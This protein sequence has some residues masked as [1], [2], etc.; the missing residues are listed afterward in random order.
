MRGSVTVPGV[1]FCAALFVACIGAKD[2][3]SR[4]TDCAAGSSCVENGG[5]RVC[6]ANAGGSGGGGSGGTGGDGGSGGSGGG[7][8]DTDGDEVCDEVDRCPSVADPGQED[9]DAD[10]LGDACDACPSDPANDEDGDGACGDV[11][12][13][14]GVANA[15]QENLDRDDLGDACDP[16]VDGDGAWDVDDCAPRDPAVFPGA[17]DPCGGADTDCV[18]G[19]CALELGVEAGWSVQDLICAPGTRLCAVALRSGDHGQIVTLGIEGMPERLGEFAA[20]GV[21]GVAIDPSHP[22]GPLLYSVGNSSVRARLVDGTDVYELKPESAT[23]S[24]PAAVS[25]I[26]RAAVALHSVD[27]NL[28]FWNPK[29]LELNGDP[30]SPTICSS[31]NSDCKL[32]YLGDLDGSGPL[33]F[34]MPHTVQVRQDSAGAPS[35]VYVSFGDDPRIAVAVI[36]VSGALQ[37]SSGLLVLD[38]LPDG[39]LLALSPDQAH[40]F[41]VT[42][43][44][45]Y[46]IATASDLAGHR[47]TSFLFSLCPRGLVALESRLVVASLCGQESA[48][49]VA[50]P[51]ADGLP[52]ESTA[53]AVPLPNCIPNRMAGSPR[54]GTDGPDALLVGCE[55][56]STVFVLGR[57]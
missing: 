16:D 37:P 57:D 52:D 29:N 50:L 34:K 27:S 6:L 53:V 21:R 35:Q 46:S 49:L 10:G 19:R 41:V 4:D 3:C 20:N 2:D 17:A 1:L 56:T 18:P 42:E 11:D 45:G 30:L 33:Q 55:G 9:T 31:T 26:R 15:G 39:S 24:G 47:P 5:H 28:Q 40:L 43:G 22:L 23:L 32:V 36:S 12:N 7:C 44:I 14:P 54:L 48:Q 25:P 51:V 13:C 38:A 8:F